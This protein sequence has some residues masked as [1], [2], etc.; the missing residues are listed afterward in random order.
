MSRDSNIGH[1]AA[2]AGVCGVL[3]VVDHVTIETLLDRWLQRTRSMTALAR[4]SDID[5][6]GRI[7][8]TGYGS[9]PSTRFG[10]SDGLR[11]LR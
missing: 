9:R 1:D 4:F 11:G 6:R 2:H 8:F 3:T 5:A 7:D 10:V